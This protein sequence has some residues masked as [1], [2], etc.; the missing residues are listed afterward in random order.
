MKVIKAAIIIFSILCVLTALVSILGFAAYFY[1]GT[2]DMSADS[3]GGGPV[4][5]PYMFAILTGGTVGM[6]AAILSGVNVIVF[7]ILL[8]I[9]RIKFK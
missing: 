8:L 2:F 6:Y 5:L 7:L 3:S 9:K 1:Y 4:G